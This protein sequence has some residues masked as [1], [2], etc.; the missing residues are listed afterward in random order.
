MKKRILIVEDDKD[1]SMIEEAYLMSAG[2]E[3]VVV[4]D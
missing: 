4:S 3:T 2:F 1:I